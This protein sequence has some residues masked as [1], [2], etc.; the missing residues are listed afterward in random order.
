MISFS[1]AISCSP[2]W[3][4]LLLVAGATNNV[5]SYTAAMGKVEEWTFAFESLRQ[6]ELAQVQPN[7]FSYGSLA[8]S[9]AL[10]QQGVQ[11]LH[12]V[13]A[14]RL[15]VNAILH[16]T[17]LTGCATSAAWDCALHLLRGVQPLPDVVAFASTITACERA[18]R[19]ELSLQLLL[20]AAA[21]KLQLNAIIYSA[22]ISACEKSSMWQAA[23][24]LMSEA[25]AA[26]ADV[27]AFNGTIS[28]CEKA[29]AWHMATGWL[30]ELGTCGV[31]ANVIT[32][33]ASISACRQCWPRALF[34]HAQCRQQ[35]IKSDVITASAAISAAAWESGVLL[36]EGLRPLNL[37]PDLTL[38]NSLLPSLRWTQTI[39]LLEQTPTSLEPDFL[40]YET[41]MTSS[42]KATEWP[43]AIELAGAV[44]SNALLL[45]VERQGRVPP[46]IVSKLFFAQADANLEKI[47]DTSSLQ[48]EAQANLKAGH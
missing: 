22:A 30:E 43:Q 38:I 45:G 32:F 36:L 16:G 46:A 2:W 4:A 6:M 37:W 17:V 25:M 34:L 26:A 47:R 28:A 48:G 14:R 9:A 33:N 21:Q 11:V 27:V 23:A 29:G 44:G 8:R 13:D 10:W 7:L 19:W 15:E 3:Q 12:A 39:E 42:I 20:D 5:V 41:V 40:S 24:L 35:G 18:S 1:S 31:Q